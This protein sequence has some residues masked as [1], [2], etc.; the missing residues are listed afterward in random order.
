MRHRPA[1]RPRALVL[2][3]ALAVLAVGLLAGC[4]G[5]SSSN[6]LAGKSPEQILAAAKTAAS[7][8][9]SVH[10]RGSIINES[11]PISLDMELVA[12]KGAKGH[13]ALEGLGID[14]ISVE[15]AFYLKGSE[16]FYRHI[17]GPAAAQLLQG[18]WLKAP[19]N[20]GEFASFSQLTNLDD[21]INSTLANH[22]TITNTGT[23]T[24]AGQKAV[25]LT[26][27]SKGG[28]LYVAATG[29]PYPLQISKTG[30]DPG[31]ITFDR[32]NQPVTLTPPANA[33]NITQLQNGH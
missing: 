15:H 13:I 17:A 21:L 24:I 5:G 1:I 30:S 29:T 20:S 7:G 16:A 6:D 2:A 9:A 18:K 19:T 27:A 25:A 28:T 26:D 3:L 33:I 8:A 22:G 11:K 14:V 23:T 4:G 10:V 32:W 12:G 31:R